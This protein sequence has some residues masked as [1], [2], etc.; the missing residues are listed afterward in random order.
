MSPVFSVMP[1][2]C[3][4][5]GTADGMQ[6]KEAARAMG[7]IPATTRGKMANNWRNIWKY[8]TEAYQ[9][10]RIFVYGLLH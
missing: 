4:V 8:L 10:K 1:S 5:W 3:T 7:E 2:A 9:T 6:T